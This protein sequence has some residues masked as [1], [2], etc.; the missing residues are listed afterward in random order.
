MARPPASGGTSGTG[1]DAFFAASVRRLFVAAGSPTVAEVARL[2]GVSNGTIS[3]WRTGR[4]FPTDF[5]TI[6]PLLVLLTDR[7][8][9]RRR[10][11]TGP[12]DGAAVLTVRQWQSLFD[13]T[14]GAEAKTPAVGQIAA[15]AEKWV[16]SSDDLAVDAVR[17]MLLDC[18][19]ISVD[20]AVTPRAWTPTSA[21]ED[22]ARTVTSEM[23][24]LGVLVEPVL[25][26]ADGEFEVGRVA[27]VDVGLIDA[28]PRL[29]RWVAD[30]YPMLIARTGLEHD[31]QRWTSAGR[32]RVWL[33]DHTRL[34]LTADALIAL[35]PTGVPI[36][37]GT[38][39]PDF[40]FGGATV[41][42]V[43]DGAIEFWIA[44]QSAA[45]SELRTHQI[46]M[47]VIVALAV[48]VLGLGI[49]LGVMAT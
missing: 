46:V 14:V 49:A 42:Q 20:G 30:S 45:L 19:E 35:S 34:E 28:W 8:H 10:N 7:A 29:A 23:I 24:D 39:D 18:L 38:A 4:H 6:E 13:T 11:S 21:G 12:E 43:P 48:M 32:P 41:S 25:R 40:R 2:T 33:Y 1:D 47:G 31:A 26:T 36:G 44:S 22:G 16:E 9:Q 17:T 5:S 37:S 3:H 27:L 15:S